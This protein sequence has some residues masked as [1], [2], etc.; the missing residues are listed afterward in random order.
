MSSNVRNCVREENRGEKRKKGREREGVFILSLF[1]RPQSPTRLGPSA[2]ES[3]LRRRLGWSAIDQYPIFILFCFIE[4]E[5]YAHVT[6]FFNGGQEAQFDGEVRQLVPSPKVAT[7]DLQPEM[8][9]QGVTDEMCKAIESDKYPFLMCNFAPPDMVGHTGKYE[10]AV[11]ACAATDKAIGQIHKSCLQHG[12]ALMITAD[13]GNAEQMFSPSGGP[14]TAHTTNRVP[15]M[16][17]NSGHKYRNIS[18]NV[19]LCDVA[20]TVLAVMG[21]PQPPEM[22]GQSLV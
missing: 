16:M 20:P 21:L 15:L 19:A 18:H 6:F 13:H 5:K 1:S 10:P 8:S 11:I 2:G 22:T 12:Y 7:Y 3:C 4:T 9:A 14:H 17:V